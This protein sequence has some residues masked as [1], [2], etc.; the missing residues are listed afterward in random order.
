MT[1]NMMLWLIDSHYTKLN[2]AVVLHLN[3]FCLDVDVIDKHYCMFYLPSPLLCSRGGLFGKRVDNVHNRNALN[4]NPLV[5]SDTL[6]NTNSNAGVPLWNKDSDREAYLAAQN[7]VAKTGHLYRAYDEKV[8]LVTGQTAEDDFNEVVPEH[9]F[10]ERVNE[11]ISNIPE[12]AA[13]NPVVVSGYNNQ[14]DKGALVQFNHAVKT[15]GN[16]TLYIWFTVWGEVLVVGE[17]KDSVNR[18]RKYLLDDM[19]KRGKNVVNAFKYFGSLNVFVVAL[20]LPTNDDGVRLRCETG[21]IA[22]LKPSCNVI[23]AIK[24]ATHRSVPQ[25]SGIK[26]FFVDKD[27]VIVFACDSMQEAA[28]VLGLDRDTIKR[29]LNQ[30]HPLFNVVYVKNDDTVTQDKL[31]AAKL[32]SKEIFANWFKNHPDKYLNNMSAIAN[33]QKRGHRI[34]AF[35]T[36]TNT[37]VGVFL[38]K[39]EASTYLK[40]DSKKL[41]KYIRSADLLNGRYLI[42][43]VTQEP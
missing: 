6:N 28:D 13:L 9:V 32:M 27:G 18:I 4:L 35:D 21:L 33:K 8:V 40:V 19:G 11:A 36:L 37:E 20:V 43:D 1:T 25:P 10:T 16:V 2:C 42:T 38:S 24:P 14:S 5:T 12:L 30:P 22:Y 31:E 7:G 23:L 26:C 39:R 15:G 34:R 41:D 17:S 29:N 3:T